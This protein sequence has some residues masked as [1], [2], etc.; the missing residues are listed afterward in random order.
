MSQNARG[1]NNGESARAMQVE[2]GKVGQIKTN[3]AKEGRWHMNKIAHWR[4]S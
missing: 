2:R 4:L 3:T 1:V